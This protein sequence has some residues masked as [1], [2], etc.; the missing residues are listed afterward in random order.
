MQPSS[1][2][3]LNFWGQ[4]MQLLQSEEALLSVG[5]V[6]HLCSWKERMSVPLMLH[7]FRGWRRA[8]VSKTSAGI[9][10]KGPLAAQQDALS[11]S[12]R[13][14][15]HMQHLHRSQNHPKQAPLVQAPRPLHSAYLKLTAPAGKL[16]RVPYRVLDR[17]TQDRAGTLSA[18]YKPVTPS[19]LMS[20][21]CRLGVSAHLRVTECDSALRG[22]M[23][24]PRSPSG[25]QALLMPMPM[26]ISDLE[27][28]RLQQLQELACRDFAQSDIIE[29]WLAY[30]HMPLQ[31]AAWCA[32][33]QKCPSPSG[34]RF[35][36]PRQAF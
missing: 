5:W 2:V 14:H 33:Y 11:L 27:P 1:A 9:L 4:E 35:L 17:G 19:W 24:P 20:A 10:V 31:H 36:S 8:V 34:H 22:M 26:P 6:R 12:S 30:A 7:S 15:G 21:A 16:I 25:A 13:L 28:A 23:Q 32:C 3:C 29:A 18:R